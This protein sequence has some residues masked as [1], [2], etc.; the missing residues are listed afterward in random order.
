MKGRNLL[1]PFEQANEKFRLTD[2]RYFVDGSHGSLCVI[3]I[4]DFEFDYL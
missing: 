1:R 4:R 3:H 2:I